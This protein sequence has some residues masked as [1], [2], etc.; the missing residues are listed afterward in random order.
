MKDIDS[1]AKNAIINNLID[2]VL[3][4]TV[5]NEQEVPI[6]V[7]TEENIV[8]ESMVL[9]QSICDESDLR[10]GGCIASEFNIDLFNT[11]STVYSNDLIGKR[12]KVMII[13]TFATEDLLYP[14][15]DL[16]PSVNLYPGNKNSSKMWCLFRGYIDSAE[17]DQSNKNIR[18]L[19][20][21]DSFA[22]MYK[23]DATNI[24]YN[25]IKNGSGFGAILKDC[26]PIAISSN[27]YDLLNTVIIQSANL[28]LNDLPIFNDDWIKDNT[29]ITAGE[30]VRMC[31]EMLGGF[32]VINQTVDH[33]AFDIIFLNNLN[34][35]G[36][37]LETY[38]FYE[39][40]YSEEYTT[41]GYN[42]YMNSIGGN[43]RN[44][45]ISTVEINENLRTQKRIYDLTDNALCW[46]ESDPSGEPTTSN[47]TLR[48]LFNSFSGTKMYA[49]EYTPLS[50][51]LDGR[52]WVECGDSIVFIV[53]QTDTEGN[54]IYDDNG[55]IK[56]ER[57]TSYV[58]SR[59]MTGIKALTDE[60]EVK[61]A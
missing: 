55:N 4:I 27:V 11:E 48:Y 14:K 49:P 36:L 19:I 15:A 39:Q 26:I 29:T 20:A 12:I 40:L 47:T 50:A 53:N 43:N 7:I 37:N 54:Y 44:E 32:G 41:Y 46:Q 25:H 21:Y 33:Y 9:K 24:L 23:I 59:T 38:D 60:I 52:P 57:I 56:T 45:K 30:V 35:Y 1:S 10:F 16:Y 34:Q 17:R 6:M 3:T 5:Y 18:H 2:N 8:S 61:G 58:L 13:Q 28:T 22:N 51:T 31:C 42:Y